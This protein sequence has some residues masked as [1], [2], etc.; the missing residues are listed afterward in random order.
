MGPGI[1]L[2]DG[3]KK[4]IVVNRAP[5]LSVDEYERGV[6]SGDR[7]VLARAVTLVESLEPSDAAM[8]RELLQ[9]LLPHSGKARRI[10]ITGVPG[11]GKSTFIDEF[12]AR[13]VA[14]AHRVAVLAIDPSSQVTGGSILGDK[15]R[16][17][18]LSVE[19]NAFIRPSPSGLTPGGIARR[20]RE[21]MLLCEAA[22]FDIVIVETVGA[23][24]GETAVADMVD[25]F[26]VLVLPGSGDELQGIKK[27]MLELADILA[28]NKAD[29]DLAPA[30]RTALADLKAAL[31][32]LPRRSETWAT[33]ALA[34]SGLTG[35]GLD[36]LW[37][38]IEEHRHVLETSGALESL[39][40]RQAR[41]WMWSLILERLEKTFRDDPR[42]VAVVADVERRVIAG[43]I[44]ASAAADSL[45]GRLQ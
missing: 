44:A 25:C 24:Q 41:A 4:G 11:V 22:G 34:I 6:L 9:R 33:R 13:L 18:R 39:R 2:G 5:R 20:T 42:I 31:R 45:L 3:R 29:G 1:R 30:A 28:V 38:A 19:P 8:G 36:E 37:S 35:L 16:M 40:G 7:T 26:L 15:T 14:R 32:H 21:A 27:G 12:G 17:Q 43:E 10:G 23:G